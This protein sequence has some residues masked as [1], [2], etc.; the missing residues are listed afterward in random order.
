MRKS[1][2]FSLSG[3]AAL[4]FSGLATANTPNSALLKKVAEHPHWYQQLQHPKNTSLVKA[5]HL[6]Q[7]DPNT[8]KNYSVMRITTK[9]FTKID[10]KGHFQVEI[11]GDTKSSAVEI[12]GTQADIYNTDLKTQAGTLTLSEKNPLRKTVTVKLATPVVEQLIDEGKV[13]VNAND[14][15]GHAIILENKGSGH[16]FATGIANYKRITLLGKGNIAINQGSADAGTL[17]NQGA[18]NLTMQGNFALKNIKDAGKGNIRMDGLNSRLLNIESTGNGN[19][20]LSGFANLQSL[21]HTGNGNVFLYWSNSQHT[22]ITASGNGVIGL[23]GQAKQVEA[24]LTGNVVY[25]ARFLRTGVTNV[26]STGNARAKVVAHTQLTAAAKGTSEIYYYN[27]PK[28]LL[29][30]STES[31]VVLP[32]NK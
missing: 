13:N 31:A 6:T 26:E 8:V 14:L 9:P 11:V 24:Q 32:L 3:T 19:I 17:L 1:L 23:A 28:H 27:Q 10:L 4:L 20:A 29:K 5:N 16:V 21:K 30:Y 15:N 22:N 2:I 25:D 7:L 12:I 18:G